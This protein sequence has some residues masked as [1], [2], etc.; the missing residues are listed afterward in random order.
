MIVNTL[1]TNFEIL[2]GRMMRKMV[3]TM[4]MNTGFNRSPNGFHF[5]IFTNPLEMS[6]YFES[7]IDS[8]MRD[9]FNFSFNQDFTTGE[10]ITDH[11][12]N[13][14]ELL[15]PST[16]RKLSPR[17][18]VF[19][20]GYD[21]ASEN[22]HDKNYKI[23]KDLDGKISAEDFSR[24]WKDVDETQLVPKNE[25]PV[26]PRSRFNFSSFGKSVTSQTIRRPDGSV[27]ERQS[28]TDS[29]GN[30]ETTI[31]RQIGD[32]IYT[33]VTKRDKY[34]VESKTENFENIPES[35]VKNFDS[36]WKPTE[37]PKINSEPL[38]KFPWEQFFDFNPKL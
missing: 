8:M 29:E 18:E 37:E 33:S 17:D 1:V 36:N 38:N 9:F 21:F 2:F 32:K 24:I 13:L 16:S 5:Q 22:P 27:E 28:V 14:P 23:D 30:C 31:K 34:G 7:Q 10:A 15:P 19:K 6:R 12:N 20:P 25:S 4:L 26:V 11:Q 3:M 35:E